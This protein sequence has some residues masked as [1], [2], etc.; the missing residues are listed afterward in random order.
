MSQEVLAQTFQ[1]A[2]ETTLEKLCHPIYFVS[3]RTPGHILLN[4]FVR[5]RCHLFGVV[6]EFGSLAGIVTLEDVLE[7][8]IGEEIV[9]ETDVAV[10]MQEVAK[11]RRKEQGNGADSQVGAD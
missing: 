8:I 4:S 5:Q 1:E 2:P 7:S 9:D 10:D 6:D 3:D 11:L